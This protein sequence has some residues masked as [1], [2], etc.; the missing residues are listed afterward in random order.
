M[1]DMIETAKP[2]TLPK[3]EIE[4]IRNL[5]DRAYEWITEGKLKMSSAQLIM[6]AKYLEDKAYVQK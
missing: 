2:A 6:I 1:N 3:D 5:L 4:I